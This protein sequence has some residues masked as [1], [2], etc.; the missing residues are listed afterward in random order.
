MPGVPKHGAKVVLMR[1][2]RSAQL[3]AALAPQGSVSQERELEKCSE[4]AGL[5][6]GSPSEQ[7]TASIPPRLCPGQLAAGGKAVVGKGK[8][9]I[10]DIFWKDEGWRRG[11]ALQGVF[12]VVRQVAVPQPRRAGA[13]G[14]CE[15]GLYGD[16]LSVWL[17]VV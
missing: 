6:P 1:A 17:T 5:C 9:L 3:P 11:M 12:L 16:R 15:R 7:P 2:A 4:Q 13:V 10:I 8:L 14:V